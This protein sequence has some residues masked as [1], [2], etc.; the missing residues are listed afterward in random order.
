[1]KDFRGNIAVITGAGTG[2]GRKLALQLVSEGC[3][4]AIC[5]VLVDNMSETEKLCEELA[6]ENT[7]VTAHECD[8]SE[9]DQAFQIQNS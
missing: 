7:L 6:P 9:E 2:M 5:G 3:N 8:V 4:V 1:M